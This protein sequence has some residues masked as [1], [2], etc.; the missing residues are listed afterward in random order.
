MG[1][2]H[3]SLNKKINKLNI[4]IQ[5]IDEDKPCVL[6]DRKHFSIKINE[7]IC[8]LASMYVIHTMPRDEP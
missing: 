4:R 7:K 8:I 3:G 1:G 2:G 6:E 5:Q